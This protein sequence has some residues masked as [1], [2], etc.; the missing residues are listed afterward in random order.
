MNRDEKNM[1]T[2]QKI[3]DSAFQEFSR[4]SYGEASLNTVCAVGNISKGIIYH[5]FKDK[6][7]LY[8]T[9]VKE[10][11]D[12]LTKRLKSV[13][14]TATAS[15]ETV[16][17]TY[18]DTRITFFEVHPLYF[19]LFCNA[20]MNPPD[21]LIS[22][23]REIKKEFDS[24]NT[25]VLTECLKTVSLRPDISVDE[26]VEVLREYQD[27][28]NMRFQTQNYGEGALKEHEEQCRRFLKV[29]L[30]GVIEREVGK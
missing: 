7:E 3:I 14:M 21:H 10:C 6:D 20:L 19:R 30:Y 18:F 28:M 25:S 12:A 8:L 26:V 27:F 29:L 17:E 2:R 16:M 9:C 15:I 23:V 1:R 22:D 5:Y 11:F 4:N 13:M 24:L